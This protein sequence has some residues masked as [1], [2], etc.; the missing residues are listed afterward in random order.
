M[1][2][3]EAMMRMGAEQGEENGCRRV[4]ERK[5]ELRSEEELLPT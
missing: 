3:S 2:G 5:C 4:V 1:V